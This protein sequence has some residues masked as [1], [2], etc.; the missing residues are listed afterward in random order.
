MLHEMKKLGAQV[1]DLEGMANHRGSAFGAIGQDEQP[2]SQQF[3]NELFHLL[4]QLDMDQPVWVESESLTI[5]KVYLPQP[6][7][8]S[9]NEAPS[10][11]LNG[12]KEI[13]V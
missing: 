9:M 12:P 10:L 2:P 13:R 7:W 1:I 11:V 5:G 6:F 3:Q 4:A 8:E